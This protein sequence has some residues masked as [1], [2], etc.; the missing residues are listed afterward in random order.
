MN[1]K[2]TGEVLK[3][4]REGKGLTQEQLAEH[5]NVSSRTVSRWETGSNMPT[6]DMLIDL[7]G[8]YDV[9][10]QEIIDGERKSENME[11]ETAN[12]LKK[13]A[14][15]A[16]KERRVARNRVVSR[17]AGCGAIV[18]ALLNMLFNNESLGLLVGV[19]P[20]SICSKIIAIV[21][22]AALVGAAALGMYALGA[23]D[24]IGQRKRERGENSRYE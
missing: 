20:G 12:T 15:Y 17:Y 24:Q 1:Q 5:F 3:S 23:F 22:S 19:I 10:I 9:N 6:V 16:V 2:K 4:L 13:V 8:F 11:I 7:A 14:E 18:V 21:T